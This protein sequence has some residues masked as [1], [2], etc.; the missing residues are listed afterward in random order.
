MLLT[1]KSAYALQITMLLLGGFV[2][3]ATDA[4]LQTLCIDASATGCVPTF[5]YSL[6]QSLMMAGATIGACVFPL[7]KKNLTWT[8]FWGA[9]IG[10]CSGLG[11][12]LPVLYMFIPS[13][14]R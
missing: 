12:L 9:K 7:C 8:E 11:V 10:I 4:I 2:T 13:A 14:Y 3:S 5:T 1:E 6:L